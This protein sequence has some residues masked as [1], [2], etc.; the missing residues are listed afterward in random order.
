MI[1]SVNINNLQQITNNINLCDMIIHVG[2][3]ITIVFYSY[4]SH[5]LIHN[6]I[7]F[8]FKNC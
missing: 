1:W 4:F 3:K 5:Q 7:L 2:L 8:I 6:I